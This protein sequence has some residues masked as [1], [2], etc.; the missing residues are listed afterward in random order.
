MPVAQR[1]GLIKN[2]DRW[3]IGASISFCAANKARLVFIRLSR[4]SLV[5]ETL[6]GWLKSQV[7]EAKIP[8]GKICFE[9]DEEVALG[10]ENVSEDW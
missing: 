8:P 10:A 5:D 9:I 6:A 2:I 4:D 7:D 3:I 1:T